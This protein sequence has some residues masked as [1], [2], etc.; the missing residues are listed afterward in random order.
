M[1]LARR[2]SSMLIL[3]DTCQASSLLLPLAEAHPPTPRDTNARNPFPRIVGLASSMLGENSYSLNID[4]HLG[5]VS[6]LF[7]LH[8]RH[9]K[10]ANILYQTPKSFA[11]ELRFCLMHAAG[12]IRSLHLLHSPVPT[13]DSSRCRTRHVYALE[14]WFFDNF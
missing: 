7:A 9:D 1:S 4:S 12:S 6:A 10:H 14:P 13:L 3:V 5:V 2:F 11:Y 8:L